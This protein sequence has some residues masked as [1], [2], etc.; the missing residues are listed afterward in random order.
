MVC[1]EWWS[2]EFV[3]LCSGFLPKPQIETSV[4]NISL[5]TACFV[6]MIPFGL[7]AAVSTRVSNE[8]GAGRPEAAK[9][10]VRVV[11]C[12]TI[13][14]GIIVGTVLIFVRNIWGYA[15]SNEAEVVKYVAIMLPLL[16]ISNM[17]DSIQSVLSGVARGC[18]WQKIGAFVNLG[19]F[20]VVG[21]PS[22]ILLA[23]VFSIGGKG[24]WIGLTCG[25]FV[26][27]VLLSIITLCTN[28][29][30]E[31]IKTKNRVFSSSFPTDI[32][33]RTIEKD[34]GENTKKR[35]FC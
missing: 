8:L 24:L 1:L 30:K 10:A 16:A 12:L 25:I 33:A 31:E 35:V 22:G 28:W 21:V 15:Y 27:V 2:F 26:Q 13:T 4:L 17:I 32:D 7:G 29:E 9:L 34:N 11:L 5:N 14:G 20:Y 6:Y 3:V 18:G 19:A 23:F